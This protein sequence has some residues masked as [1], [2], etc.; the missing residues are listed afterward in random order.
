MRYVIIKSLRIGVS[1]KPEIYIIIFFS[2]LIIPAVGVSSFHLV[3]QKTYVRCVV[4]DFELEF[5]YI[6]AFN[7]TFRYTQEM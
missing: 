6:F 4:F 1:P 3:M 7:F 5:C 2:L